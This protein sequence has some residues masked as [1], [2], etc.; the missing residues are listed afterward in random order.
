MYVPL[1][2]AINF[3]SDLHLGSLEEWATNL[4]P[5]LQKFSTMSRDMFGIIVLHESMA[6]WISIMDKL[7][8]KLV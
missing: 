5:F 1:T 7:N 2:H 6:A 4:F 8:Q 3:L